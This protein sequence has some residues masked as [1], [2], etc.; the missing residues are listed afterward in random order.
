METLRIVFEICTGITVIAGIIGGLFA[1][2]RWLANVKNKD[3]KAAKDIKEL[4]DH[5][6]NEFK[7]IK[8][9][10]TL[11]CYGLSACLDGLIQQGCNHTVPLAKDKLDK[12]LNQKAHE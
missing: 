11:I 1:V 5:T 2:F 3:D 10:N 7:A 6:E 9:E 4:R 12:H 8:D